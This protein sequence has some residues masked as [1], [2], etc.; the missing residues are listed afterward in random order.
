MGRNKPRFSIE[1]RTYTTQRLYGARL[2]K[3]DLFLRAVFCWLFDRSAGTYQ[4]VT[5]DNKLGARDVSGWW[6]SYDT[7]ASKGVTVRTLR[8]RRRLTERDL[9]SVSSITTGAVVNTCPILKPTP[10]RTGRDI[11]DIVYDRF[12]FR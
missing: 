5:S 10:L 1:N 3:R 12:T 4:P 9:Y 6:L 2:N 11:A 8:F 7:G